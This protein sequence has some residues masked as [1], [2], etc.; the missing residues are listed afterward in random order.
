MGTFAAALPYI[1][2][3]VA[4]GASVYNTNRTAKKQDEAVA[5]GI[6]KKSEVQRRADGKIADELTQLEGSTSA[7]ERQ[8][9][10]NQ[11]QNALRGTD[12]QAQA[13]QALSGLSKE[14]D[15]ATG[16]AQQRTKGYVD[17]VANS[18]SRID[19]AGLQRQ[20]EGMRVADLGTNL[21]VLGREGEGIDYLAN[22]KAQG[23][24]RNPYI[25]ALSSALN[26]YGGG[27]SGAAG[28]YTN[29][30]VKTGANYK[31]G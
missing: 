2:A 11:Y 21:R 10:L 23:V 29:P 14:Y 1:A 15:A 13:G 26:S 4:T 25:D 27:M 30:G 9:T 31:G 22:M 19:A 5:A 20:G 8:S 16:A 6:R 12:Q 18:L 7:D 17:Q 28:S 3:V 24:R